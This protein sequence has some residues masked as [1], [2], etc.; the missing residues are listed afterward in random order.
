M[1]AFLAQRGGI[2]QI[3]F[4]FTCLSNSNI[5]DNCIDGNR[6]KKFSDE[7]CKVFSAYIKFVF[8]KKATKNDK[9]FTVDL[10]LT[11]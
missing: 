4:S 9:I 6:V 8:S 10:T 2:S 3:F 5:A 11:T 1:Y 7:V